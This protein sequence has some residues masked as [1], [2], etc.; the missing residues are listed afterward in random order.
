MPVQKVIEKFFS[1][2]KKFLSPQG[3]GCHMTYQYV[4]KSLLNNIQENSKIWYQ[5]S[6]YGSNFHIKERT[7]LM[8]RAYFVFRQ[9]ESRDCGSEQ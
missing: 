7:K 6:L 9:S 8:F 1:P 2:K 5:T 3:H 4:E